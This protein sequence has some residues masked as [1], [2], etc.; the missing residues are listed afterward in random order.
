MLRKS[1]FLLSNI[2]LLF[3]V[4]I[5]SAQTPVGTPP[6]LVINSDEVINVESRLVIVPV[7]VT[8]GKGQAVKGLGTEHFR[9]SENKRM[10]E[11]LE[12]SAAEKV[13]LEIA[14]LFDISGS[15]DPMFKFEQETAALF[16]QDVMRSEDRA[17]IF[18]IGA[19]PQLI[20][21]S[22]VAYKS[23]EAIRG[24][25]P[26]RQYTAFYDTVMAA[27]NYLRD[28]ADP[29]SRKIIIAITD[30]EDTNSLGIRRGFAEIYASV[31]ERINEISVKEYRELLVKKRDEIRTREQD[32]TLQKLQNADTVFYSINP[33]GSSYKL[34]KI[35]EF[36]QS[37]MQKFAVETGGTAFLPRFFPTDLKS[38]YE[39]TSNLRKNTETLATIFS[40]LKNELQA[41]Y[42]IQYYS[43]GDFA[44]NEYVN[45]DLRINLTL[46]QGLNVRSRK[47]YFVKKQ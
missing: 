12:V 10:Q 5:A 15:T 43:D 41:Q 14:L 29:K 24:L 47:G 39:N 23:V 45:I 3:S 18:T 28:N 32:K 2:F 26:T 31:G 9:V 36:G 20:Q 30:G 13:P 27:A 34:N 42:L 4:M 25:A 46:P 22:N 44:E 1:Q 40:T 8:D 35:S 6:A 37:N 17:T 38:T 7:S 21:S 33:A 11:V 19:V 16:L